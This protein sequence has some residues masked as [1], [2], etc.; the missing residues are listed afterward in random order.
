MYLTAVYDEINCIVQIEL[1]AVDWIN[2][3]YDAT[4]GR[5]DVNISYDS[6]DTETYCSKTANSCSINTA[7]HISTSFF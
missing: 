4:N 2:C 1:T 5:Y 3:S 6:W 7:R